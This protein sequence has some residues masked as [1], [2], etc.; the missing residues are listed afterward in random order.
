MKQAALQFAKPLAAKAVAR[1]ILE[2]LNI[3]D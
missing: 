1:E 3:N 2:Y